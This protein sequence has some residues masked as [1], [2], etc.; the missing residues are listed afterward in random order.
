LLN[1]CVVHVCLLALLW[2][3]TFVFA[4]ADNSFK[5]CYNYGCKRTAN[6]S[7]TEAEWNEVGRLFAGEAKSPE[8]ERQRIGKAIALMESLVGRRTGTSA[9]KGRNQATGEPGQLDCIAESTNTL[10]YLRIF[11]SNR[12]MKWHRVKPRVRRNPFI[13]DIHWTAVIEEQESGK[14]YA[15]DSWFFDNGIPPHIQLLEDWI[16]KRNDPP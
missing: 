7:L 8:K 16:H 4:K 2:Q 15:V 13:F 1:R 10:T 11:E 3:A 14:E 12:W 6:I 9:D 5:V